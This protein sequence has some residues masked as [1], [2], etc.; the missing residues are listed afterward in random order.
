MMLDSSS[1]MDTGSLN[2]YR[3]IGPKLAPIMYDEY[4]S[5]DVV[6]VFNFVSKYL[7]K[8]DYIL[9]AGAYHN[10]SL[11]M[12]NS[13]KFEHLYGFDT[14][15]MYNESSLY[16]EPG[17]IR[18]K[19]FRINIED[20]HFP[21]N[22]FKAIF[23]LSVIEH[24]DYS[25]GEIFG[26][27]ENFLREARRLLE[28]NGFLVITTD[29][30]DHARFKRGQN[31]FDREGILKII[32]IAKQ[33]GF[34]LMF[35]PSLEIKDKPVYFYHM[36][37]TFIFIAFVLHKKMG[38]TAPTEVNILTP[39]DHRDG[40]SIYARMLQRRFEEVGIKVHLYQREDEI[41]N[42]HPTILELFSGKL[43]DLP[44][45]RRTIIE[46]HNTPAS[47]IKRFLYYLLRN[48]SIEMARFSVKQNRE[49]RRYTLLIRSP[50][51]IMGPLS[52]A[53]SYFFMPHI[54]Y[55]DF[56]IR[57]D[58]SGICIGTF[59]F[60]SKNKRFESICDLA[61]RLNVPAIILMSKNDSS[62]VLKIQKYAN[63]IIRKYS[64]FENIKI[65]FGFLTEDEILQE[66]KNCSHII[67]NQKNSKI[68]TS[69]SYRFLAQLG[70]PIIS[71]NSFQAIESQVY[72]VKSLKEVTLDYL[73]QTKEPVNQD[74]G[75]RYLLNILRYDMR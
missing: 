14:S 39:Q 62:T 5:F 42:E 72:R 20:T 56:G 38:T 68:Q 3:K 9:F 51:L 41:K 49:L 26:H 32:M 37:Y 16:D 50:E 43:Q 55:P 1:V 44:K 11:Q 65:S 70:V 12:L 75:F 45:N 54:A 66:L 33:L 40:I 22:F 13:M 60:L 8:S 69:G 17:Y 36:N 19:Y 2:E 25:G 53:S 6:K 21:S 57:A 59:G 30:N 64:A 71:T 23:S 63:K 18:I 28:D 27:I 48:R 47:S 67:F 4:K 35:D 34:E 74:D 29:Y 24:L 7:R 61:V 73:R 15:E 46:M 31:V 10:A 52:K 58:P